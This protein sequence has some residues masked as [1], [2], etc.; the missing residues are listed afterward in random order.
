MLWGESFIYP[1]N[2]EVILS[3]EG[4]GRKDFRKPSKPSDVG[5]HWIALT[6]YSQMS[7]HVG[8]GTFK[9]FTIRSDI[10]IF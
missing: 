3:S 5:I 8:I 6:E 2:A 9:I 7:T 1:S 10:D 4:Q